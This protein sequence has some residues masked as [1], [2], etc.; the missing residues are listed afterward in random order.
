MKFIRKPEPWG[1]QYYCK[2]AI[3]N[4]TEK[5]ELLASGLLS[6]GKII[7]TDILPSKFDKTWVIS[8][9]ETK[10]DVTPKKIG[11]PNDCL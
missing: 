8:W 7:I 2:E 11:E 4:E 10:Q 3:C 1:Y 6:N 9:L 5:T